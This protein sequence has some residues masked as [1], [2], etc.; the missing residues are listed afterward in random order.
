MRERQELAPAAMAIAMAGMM[1]L[2]ALPVRAEPLPCPSR[3]SVV[4]EDA[5]HLAVAARL[6]R[7]YA[8][9][10][11]PDVVFVE[12]PG[13]RGIAAFNAG[14]VDGDIGRLQIAEAE[15][16]RPFVRTGQPV[17]VTVGRLWSRRTQ[18]AGPEAGNFGYVL[19]VLWQER[20][21]R[22][23]GGI[24]FHGE[25]ELFAAYQGG[26]IDRFLA[27]DERV[28]LALSDGRLAERPPGAGPVLESAPMY[29][30]LAPAFAATAAA[31]DALLAARR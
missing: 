21:G 18:D 14:A 11:C 13:R 3:L 4:L 12:M 27:G 26:R 9:L 19:G 28:G 15:F 8:T 16:T 17:A 24:V 20:I 2:A 22:A 6:R 30:Y 31:L 1:L 10:G 7:L 5:V 29:H 25:S 23:H